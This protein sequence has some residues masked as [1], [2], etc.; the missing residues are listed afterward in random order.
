MKNEKK[1]TETPTQTLRGAALSGPGLRSAEEIE[2]LTEELVRREPTPS[3]WGNKAATQ[4]I[5]LALFVAGSR[6]MT[7]R[8]LHGI[9]GV[10]QSLAH[11]RLNQLSKIGKIEPFGRGV[12]RLT[13]AAREEQRK[14]REARGSVAGRVFGLA[15]SLNNPGGPGHPIR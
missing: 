1:A 12:W 3:S 10:S 11:L 15:H 4:A 8:E 13:G 2:R 6:G 14:I 9:T 5:L 7:A